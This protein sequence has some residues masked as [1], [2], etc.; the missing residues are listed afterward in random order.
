MFYS[1][2]STEEVV[3]FPG[4]KNKGRRAFFFGGA[5]AVEGDLTGMHE[6]PQKL[7]QRAREDQESLPGLWFLTCSVK[8][9]H[10]HLR[11]TSK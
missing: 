7:S 10:S 6:S 5:P 8:S 3:D 11:S 4:P 2:R 1:E 9:P